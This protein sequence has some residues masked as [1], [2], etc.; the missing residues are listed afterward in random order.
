M[1]RRKD[2]SPSTKARRSGYAVMHR[3]K[4]FLHKVL[5]I[6]NSPYTYGKTYDENHWLEVAFHG[7]GWKDYM[8]RHLPENKRGGPKV[9]P[10]SRTKRK[11][12]KRKDRRNT[13][14]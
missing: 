2:N 1:A 9:I 12:Q 3:L 13:V 4:S 6:E 14:R 8:I 11:Q 7:A 10:P 5:D